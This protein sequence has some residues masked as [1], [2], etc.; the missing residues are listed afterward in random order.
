[1][2][3][4]PDRDDHHQADKPARIFAEGDQGRVAV[5]VSPQQQTF[6]QCTDGHR[7]DQSPEYIIPNL[8]AKVKAPRIG[9]QWARIIM[10]VITLAFEGIQQ[11]V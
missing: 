10:L 3:P 4:A 6:P 8:V 9:H 7:T 11:Q 2:K 1:M 5:S